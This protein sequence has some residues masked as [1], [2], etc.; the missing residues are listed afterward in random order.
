MRDRGDSV[1]A[2]SDPAYEVIGRGY[3]DIRQPHLRIVEQELLRASASPYLNDLYPGYRG[4]EHRSNGPARQRE[5]LSTSVVLIFGLGPQ[6]RLLDPNDPAHPHS[7]LGSFV[8][9]LDDACAVIEHDG[10]MPG[11][12]V[13]LTPLAAAATH[14]A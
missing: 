10:L 9:G 8:A 2:V 6:L 4:Y 12:Q 5:R 11:I 1:A 7:R 14:S 13:D 3:A